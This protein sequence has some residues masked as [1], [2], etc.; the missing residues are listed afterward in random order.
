[1][2]DKSISI[3]DPNDAFW[4]AEEIARH[5]KNED[6]ELYVQVHEKAIESTSSR[7]VKIK[8]DYP[9]KNEWYRRIIGDDRVTPD[10]KM[11]KSSIE[12]TIKIYWQTQYR[13][14]TLNYKMFFRSRRNSST[15]STG[16]AHEVTKRIRWRFSSISSY[17]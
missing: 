15:L 12:R 11:R 13:N 16:V 10:R 14:A 9:E 8:S 6:P 3:K 5:F 7:H 17:L 2:L 1:M 4:M